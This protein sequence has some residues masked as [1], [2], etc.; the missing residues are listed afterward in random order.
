MT[1]RERIKDMV[2]CI[3]EHIENAQSGYDVSDCSFVIKYR[4]GKIVYIEEYD[5]PEKVCLNIV[6]IDYI[7][8]NS[9]DDSWD[10]NGKSWFNDFVHGYWD[11]GKGFVFDPDEYPDSIQEWDEYVGKILEG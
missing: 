1:K 4:D 6:K 5:I 9:A 11:N 7:A 10:T 8:S 2:D 3:R